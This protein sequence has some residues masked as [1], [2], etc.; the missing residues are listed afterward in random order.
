MQVLTD[1]RTLNALAN[2]YK[3]AYDKDKKYIVNLGCLRG[4][5]EKDV[6]MECGGQRYGIYTFPGC[7]Y[8]FVCKRVN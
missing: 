1:R 5:S 4:Y 3:F 8:P 2:R 6:V 7:Q